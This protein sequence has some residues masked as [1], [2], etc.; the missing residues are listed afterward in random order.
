MHITLVSYLYIIKEQ[1]TLRAGVIV[2]NKVN[3]SKF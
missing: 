2:F 1:Y 3:Y